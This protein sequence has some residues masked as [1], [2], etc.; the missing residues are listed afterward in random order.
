M[1]ASSEP[2]IRIE[3]VS[4][5]FHTKNAEVHA[6]DDVSLDIPQG[7][8]FGIV[9]TSGAGK[10][11]LLRMLNLLDTPSSG[12]VRFRGTALDSLDTKALHE[13]A[14]KVSTV[15][16]NFNLFH[17]RTVLENVAFPLT[18][19]KVTK[20]ERT[21]RAQRLIDLVGLSGK[22]QAYPSQLSGGQQ[23]RVGIARALISNPE[24]LLCDEAT[25]ALDSETTAVILDLLSDLKHRL[26]FTVVLITHSW[27]VVRYACDAVALVQHGKLVETGT[28]KKLLT[29]PSSKLGPLL[30][31]AQTPDGSSTDSELDLVF[32]G[33]VQQSRVLSQLA[34]DLQV[35][36]E[37]VSGRVEE[38]AGTSFSRFLV[39]FSTPAGDAVP[40]PA[41]RKR[42]TA[43]GVEIRED[44]HVR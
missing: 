37:L 20:P 8:F 22:E 21:E 13:Y 27:D 26:G 14:R 30:V 2:I 32:S 3:H 44:A 29:D 35:D 23:Q 38:I 12:H 10:S 41:I 4:K 11:T 31:P 18:V 5:T 40:L 15:F 34:R 36:A 17:G 1:A 28:V 9:G 43:S 7:A 42:L 25:S 39:R 16:Q 19:R 24:V 6:L 33:G